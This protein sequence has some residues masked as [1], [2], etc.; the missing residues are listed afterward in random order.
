MKKPGRNPA[1]AKRASKFS[2][3]RQ[4]LGIVRQCVQAVDDAGPFGGVALARRGRFVPG[5]GPLDDPIE[6]RID[7]GTGAF[8]DANRR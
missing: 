4:A 1:L 5:F 2:F 3:C 8:L 7:V 6:R